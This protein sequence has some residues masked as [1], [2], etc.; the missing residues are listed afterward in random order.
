MFGLILSQ[1]RVQAADVF[2]GK[3]D[4]VAGL[5]L[6][7]PNEVPKHGT[8]WFLQRPNSPPAPCNSLPELPVY[9]LNKERHVFLLDD[10]TVDYAALYEQ[11]LATRLL[12][13]GAL[14]M[15]LT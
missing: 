2:S 10:R 11:R 4:P 14:G 5:E 8:F 12:E 6:V 7:A 1:V 9:W 15:S 3:L 13:A